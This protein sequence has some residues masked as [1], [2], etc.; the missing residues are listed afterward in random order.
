MPGT[1]ANLRKIV[2]RHIREG[3]ASEEAILDL[4]LR[5]VVDERCEEKLIPILENH[6]PR[7][8]KSREKK[9]NGSP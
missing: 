1:E 5:E 2:E 4:A 8:H 7:T 6:Q 3:F 9:A